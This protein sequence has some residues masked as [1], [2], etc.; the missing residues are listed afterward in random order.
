[1]PIWDISMNKIGLH[2]ATASRDLTAKL[3]SL[4]R[5]FPIRS[6]AGHTHSVDVCIS[7]MII[8]SKLIY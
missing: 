8:L 6:F 3:W 5:T 2:I 7:I 4:E 1:M